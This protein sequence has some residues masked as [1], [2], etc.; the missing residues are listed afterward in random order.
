[1]AKKVH[2]FHTVGNSPLDLEELWLLPQLQA[3]HAHGVAFFETYEELLPQFSS[4]CVFGRRHCLVRCSSLTA[5]Q[6]AL[7][8][9]TFT[10][11]NGSFLLLFFSESAGCST[12]LSSYGLFKPW[13]QPIRSLAGLLAFRRLVDIDS[14]LTLGLAAGFDFQNE[15]HSVRFASDHFTPDQLESMMN[16]RL[17]RDS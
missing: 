4:E 12:A 14:F 5:G 17:V 6:R 11:L 7:A 9:R 1:M 10:E 8:Y 16:G 3:F 2:H 13:Y 15:G